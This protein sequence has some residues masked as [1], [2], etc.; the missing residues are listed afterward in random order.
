MASSPGSVFILLWRGCFMRFSFCKN[1][2][3]SILFLVSFLL[4]T[5]C[6]VLLFRAVYV[7]H[8]G[9]IEDYGSALVQAASHAGLSRFLF[10]LM[11]FLVLFLFGVF[12]EGYRLVPVLI[13]A[14]GCFLCYYLSC[15]Q[16]SGSGGGPV[17]FRNLILLPVFYLLSR[18]IWVYC[19]LL[20]EEI[21]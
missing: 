14:R 1:S 10:A 3:F 15:C 11:P 19:P 18:Y 6:G 2:V 4:G 5:I 13:A 21:L 12:S 16:V 20:R 17:L 7:L 9:W 8:P